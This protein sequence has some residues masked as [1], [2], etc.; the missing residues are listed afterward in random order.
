MQCNIQYD[1]CQ[2]TAVMVTNV[3]GRRIKACRSCARFSRTPDAFRGKALKTTWLAQY[4]QD[5]RDEVH[6]DRAEFP[7]ADYEWA[8]QARTSPWPN[9]A[10]DPRDERE[11]AMQILRQSRRYEYVEGDTD[12]ELIAPPVHLAQVTDQMRERYK[13]LSPT[14]QAALADIVLK[15]KYQDS[16]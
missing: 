2:G 6:F 1:G 13:R 7:N 4:R 3:G 16:K 8:W 10:D 9:E 14:M 15:S 5:V 12:E 11:I